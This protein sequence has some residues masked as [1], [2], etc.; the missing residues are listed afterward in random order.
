MNTTKLSIIAVALS[1]TFLAC[2]S[3]SSKSN[4]VV[5]AN[6]ESKTENIAKLPKGIK[7][8]VSQLLAEEDTISE[9]RK[10]QLQNIAKYIEEKAKSNSPV[11]LTFICTHNSRR[12]HLSQIWAQ[13]AAVYYSIP[14]VHCFSGGTEATAFNHRSVKALRTA[15]FKIDQ[16]D[17][18]KNPKYKVYF[19]ADN[20]Y[21]EGF[22]KK[23]S[24]KSNPQNDFVALMT[25]S[26]ADQACPLVP[27]AASRFAIPY[28]DPK[29]AD[30]TPNEEKKYNERCKQIATEM[31]YLFSNV[32]L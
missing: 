16:L 9:E 2:N 11:N 13:T 26:H 3:N 21:M 24:D 10:G 29:V 28:L 25:C 23:F 15:G 5:N 19:D 32:S 18:S 22:S 14:N 30:N 27:G 1:F 6:I 7:N 8:Y 4:K 31:F 17:E 20:N 12:S